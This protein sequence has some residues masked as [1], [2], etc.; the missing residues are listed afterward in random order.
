[1]RAAVSMAFVV[2]AAIMLYAAPALALDRLA[3]PGVS[4]SIVARV[5]DLDRPT[6][7]RRHRYHGA[8][9]RWHWRHRAAYVRWLHNEYVRSGYPVRH[10]HSRTYVVVDR[11]CCC[12]RDRHW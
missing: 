8:E 3:H 9:R 4:A 10:Y 11:C 12:D 1:M 6:Y 2:L 7:T 5:A